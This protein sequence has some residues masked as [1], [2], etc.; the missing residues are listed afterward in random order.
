MTSTHS[1]AG[2]R[3][4]NSDAGAYITNRIGFIGSNFFSIVQAPDHNPNDFRT[5]GYLDTL[6][7]AELNK[8]EPSYIIYSYNTPIAWYGKVGWVIP[9]VKYSS[10][11]SRHQSL[12]RRAI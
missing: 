10:T 2:T 6:L 1:L 11:T 7:I 5:Y 3:I 8:D 9:S 12:V 4:S